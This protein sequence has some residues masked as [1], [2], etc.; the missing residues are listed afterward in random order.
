MKS[1]NAYHVYLVDDDT[2]FLN[3]LEHT[4]KQPS[5]NKFDLQSFISG[6]E[7]LAKVQV[8]PP[9][10]VVLDYNLD[11]NSGNAMNGIKV[12]NKIKAMNRNIQVIMLSSQEKLEVAVNCIKSGAYDYVIKNESASVRLRHGIDL[13][14]FNIDLK[15][16]MKNYLAWNIILASTF[17]LFLLSMIAYAYMHTTA[18][19]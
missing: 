11:S 15:K 5:E 14:A 1:E 7:C 12:L 8:S 4:L 2:M 9:D 13:I 19:S 16:K 6:E 10:I 18:N 3:T 17:L